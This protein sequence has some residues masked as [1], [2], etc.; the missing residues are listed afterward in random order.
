[1]QEIIFHSQNFLFL[2]PD[3]GKV[4]Y[5]T[6]QTFENPFAVTARSNRLYVEFSSN[7]NIGEK[8]FQ[9]PYVTYDGK[10]KGG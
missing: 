6:C 4:T 9:I 7:D 5:Q 3:H 1:M 2:G 10:E 8:G